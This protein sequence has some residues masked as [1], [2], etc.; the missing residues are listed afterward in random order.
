MIRPITLERLMWIHTPFAM[1]IKQSSRASRHYPL[2]PSSITPCILPLPPSTF[3]S[4]YHKPWLNATHKAFLF[5]YHHHSSAH[6]YQSPNRIKKQPP[7]LQTPLF[8]VKAYGII[9]TPLFRKITLQNI[10]TPIDDYHWMPQFTCLA[11]P[12]LCPPA[13]DLYFAQLAHNRSS[14]T[15]PY[16]TVYHRGD[17][18]IVKVHIS[19]PL[20]LLVAHIYS[21]ISHRVLFPAQPKWRVVSKSTM[22]HEMRR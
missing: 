21:R 4:P 20:L 2:H 12:S 17:R 6:T 1:P 18:H 5:S 19:F 10:L 15:I 16:T 9:N 8:C 13:Q 7:S 22:T 14:S 3:L 11:N